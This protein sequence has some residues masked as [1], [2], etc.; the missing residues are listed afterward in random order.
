MLSSYLKD[1]YS[2]FS[3]TCR[4]R[5]LK[6]NLSRCNLH[7]NA[8]FTK[9]KLFLLFL[10]KQTPVKEHTND[11]KIPKRGKVMEGFTY[12]SYSISN[13]RG[14]TL[15]FLVFPTKLF[16]S[17]YKQPHQFLEYYSETVV[18]NKCSGEKCH[19]SKV[20]W[21]EMDKSEIIQG[22]KKINLRFS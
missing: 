4:N 18:A 21:Q 2:Y 9:T 8:F 10:Q 1:Q 5:V 11:Q 16:T 12:I 20:K 13:E 17:I 7:Y 19:L 6:W 14:E 3:I 22:F 15:L